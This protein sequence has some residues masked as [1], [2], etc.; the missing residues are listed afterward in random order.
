MERD[1]LLVCAS[2]TVSLCCVQ[3]LQDFTV[4][5]RYLWTYNKPL[6][7]NGA[8]NKTTKLFKYI[9]LKTSFGSLCFINIGAQ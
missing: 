1:D 9:Y 6:K 5:T 3:S 7:L 8:K 2:M 4:A